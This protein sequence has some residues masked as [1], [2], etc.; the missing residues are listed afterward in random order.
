MCEA[1]GPDGGSR[2]TSAR[3]PGQGLCTEAVDKTIDGRILYGKD[4]QR[5]T[6]LSTRESVFTVER[7]IA[8]PSNCS[9]LARIVQGRARAAHRCA[10]RGRSRSRTLNDVSRRKKLW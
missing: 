5:M 3:R 10:V 4:L 7:R 1:A 2:A 8:P 6:T 9:R